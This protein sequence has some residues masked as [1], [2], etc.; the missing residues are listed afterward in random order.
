L[1]FANNNINTSCI[2]FIVEVVIMPHCTKEVR[3]SAYHSN[4]GA[5]SRTAAS[6]T[7]RLERTVLQ[8]KPAERI[9]FMK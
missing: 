3:A 9:L 7:P 6:S 2:V 4:V 5:M 8:G 1:S